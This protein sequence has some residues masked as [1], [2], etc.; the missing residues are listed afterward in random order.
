MCFKKCCLS[1]T[2]KEV[3]EETEN[4]NCKY[5]DILL[6]Q[7]KIYK[8]K[9]IKFYTLRFMQTLFGFG[10]TTLTTVNNPYFKDNIDTIGILIWYISISNNII[11]LLIEKMQLS[12]ASLSDDKLKVKL[13]I[14]ENNKF[15]D[16]YKDYSLYG[17]QNNKLK[18]LDKCCNEIFNKTPYEYLVFQGRRP[19]HD[20]IDIKQKKLNID[21]A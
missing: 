14:G 12:N 19:S 17:N 18:Y 5:Q 6:K 21:K 8:F 3:L 11:N 1:K 15:I 2:I 10:L 20:T 16:N 7:Y 9:K 13:I 4:Y